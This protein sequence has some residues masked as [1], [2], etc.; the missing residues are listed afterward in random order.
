MHCPSLFMNINKFSSQILEIDC[1]WVIHLEILPLPVVSQ[2]SINPV[3]PL[4]IFFHGLLL[5][6]L[7]HVLILGLQILVPFSHPHST[8]IGFP[9]SNSLQPSHSKHLQEKTPSPTW[10]PLGLS[11]T[12]DVTYVSQS[13]LIPTT[14]IH[15]IVLD[16]QRDPRVPGCLV[17][18]QLP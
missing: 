7:Y 11:I 10:T 15:T 18:R 4:V 1:V 8:F 6:L 5:P 16:D 13:Q 3:T 12:S 17:H 9:H 2:S 14:S